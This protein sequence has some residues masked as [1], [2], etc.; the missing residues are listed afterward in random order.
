MADEQSRFASIFR[1]KGNEEAPEIKVEGD[2]ATIV[3]K[4]DEPDLEVRMPKTK[5]A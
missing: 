1:R 5:F 4:T 3:S 2:K